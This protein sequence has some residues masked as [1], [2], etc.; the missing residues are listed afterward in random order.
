MEVIP[1]GTGTTSL[2]ARMTLPCAFFEVTACGFSVTGASAVNGEKVVKT[3]VCPRLL[4]EVCKTAMAAARVVETAT[5]PCAFVEA[6][7]IGTIVADCGE[8]GL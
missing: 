5:L 3:E 4:V 1:T 8:A 7:A 2:V 6:T